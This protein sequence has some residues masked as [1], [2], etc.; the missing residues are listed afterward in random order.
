[1]NIPPE[2]TGR[3]NASVVRVMAEAGAAINATFR[4]T[5]AALAAPVSG[6]CTSDFARLTLPPGG[7][8]FDYVVTMEDMAHGA[9]VANYSVEYRAEGSDAWRVLVPPV[10]A[11]KNGS[12]WS[13]SASS[14]QRLGGRYGDRPDGHDP[15]DSHVGRKRID[16]PVVRTRT[17]HQG[18]GGVRVAEVR[19]NCIEAFEAPVHLKGFSLHKRTVPWEQEQKRG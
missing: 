16:L 15:R 12:S 14:S 13:A 18:Q 2:R 9:R 17:G 3:M 4:V 6:D 8:A 11:K 7:A 5:V 10:P 19:F 1:M